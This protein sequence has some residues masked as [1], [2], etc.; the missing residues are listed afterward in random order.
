MKNQSALNWIVPLIAALALF[1]AGIG[2][3]SPNEGNSFSFMSVRGETV[4]IWGQGWYR[5]DTPIGALGFKAGDLITLFLAIPLLLI[6]FVL[7]RRGSLRGGLLLAGSLAYFLYNYISLGFGA[8][9]NNLFLV[10][11]IIFSASLFGMILALASFDLPALPAYFAESLPRR[12]MGI[13]LVVSGIILSL[14]W[15]M[16]SIVPAL[17]QSKAPPEAYYYTTFM[18]GILDIGII[19][20][21]LILAGVWILRLAPLGYLL[22]STMLVFTSILGPS[23]TTAGIMQVL[24]EVITIGQAMVFTVPFVILALIAIGLTVRLFSNFSEVPYGRIALKYK[25]EARNE[26]YSV[27]EH[28]SSSS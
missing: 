15:L 11:I 19:A 6:S 14:V 2:L 27:D 12:G 8:A 21:A 20:P 28:R 1:A 23:L 10:Y 17:L 22:A 9:Y 24:A 7:Y 18:T 5:Y 25:T 16:L 13:F 26:R 3:F 4:Q